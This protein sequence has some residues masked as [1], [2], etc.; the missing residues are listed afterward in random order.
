ML[1]IGTLQE[2]SLEDE[3]PVKHM[4][5]ICPGWLGLHCYMLNSGRAN[6]GQTGKYWCP[7][8]LSGAVMFISSAN[9]IIQ[10]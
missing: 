3:F 8:R 7:L 10:T 5:M 1:T 2:V 4:A 6:H 9:E